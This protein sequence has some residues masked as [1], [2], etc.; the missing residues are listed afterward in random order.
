MDLGITRGIRKP[1]YS[2]HLS[3]LMSLQELEE[4]QHTAPI[5]SIQSIDHFADSDSKITSS[6]VSQFASIDEAGCIIFWVTSQSTI[7]DIEAD[8]GRSPWGRLSLVVT[9]KLSP[10]SFSFGRGLGHAWSSTEA[11]HNKDRLTFYSLH[12]AVQ[13]AKVAFSTVPNDPSLIL[14]SATGGKIVKVGRFGDAPHPHVFD[15]SNANNF[16]VVC[17]ES[18]TD[19]GGGSKAVD[20][21]LAAT[22]IDVRSSYSLDHSASS[23]L[24][25]VGRSDGSIDL[26]QL[27]AEA[28]L[29]SW[30]LPSFLDSAEKSTTNQVVLVRWCPK[31]PSVFFAVDEAANV[32]LFDLSNNLFRPVFID[33]LDSSHIRSSR[34]DIST[35]APGSKRFHL[36]LVDRASNRG[37]SVKKLNKSILTSTFKNLAD[38]EDHFRESLS[39]WSSRNIITNGVAYIGSSG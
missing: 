27:D 33:K 31:R 28:P 35:V 36:L 1:C 3:S 21:F 24:F 11:T 6:V 8:F 39:K 34:I 30:N 32:Y 15:R 29:V 20:F 37:I 13:Q 38:E 14:V 22:C 12:T 23:C 18:K 9:K 19:R 16:D 26:F 7:D 2:S 10:N 4:D 5:M 17:G 25:L